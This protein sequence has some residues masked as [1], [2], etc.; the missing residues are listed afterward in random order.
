MEPAAQ[1]PVKPPVSPASTS[2]DT[3]QPTGEVKPLNIGDDAFSWLES[4]AAKQ[5]AKPEELLTKPNERSGEMPDW[6]RQPAD[7][8]AD[9]PV[10]PAQEPIR[11]PPETLPLKPLPWFDAQASKPAHPMNETVPAN[12]ETPSPVPP[13]EPTAQPANPAAGGEDDTMAW[14]EQMASDKDTKPEE[15]LPSPAKDVGTTPEWIQKV[16]EDQP[17]GSEPEEIIPATLESTP[18]Q[19]DISITSW[20]SKMDVDEALEKKLGENPAE[21]VPATPAEELPDWLKDLEKPVAPAE[22]PKADTDLPEWLRHPIPS[23][24]LESVTPAA[25]SDSIPEAEL[26]TWVDENAPVTGQAVPTMPEEWLPVET[27]AGEISSSLPATVP[28]PVAESTPNIDFTGVSDSAPVPPDEAKPVAETEPPAGSHPV[29]APTPVRPPTLKQTGMLSHI[30][31][32][33]KDA[34]LL[35]SAQNVLDQNSL[36]DAMKKYSKLIKKGRLLDEVIHDLR[37]AIYRYPVDVIVWQTLG[38]AYMRA[39]R[40]QDALDAYTKAEE[41]L[42]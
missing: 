37:E 38:D 8:A 2:A 1:V 41:L 4:L 26:P 31:V 19:E 29:S 12:D 35:S 27:N 36:D 39:N 11:T 25:E 10:P 34:E 22:A 30:P 17:A 15:P 6:L 40:L 20:L 18:T 42:R 33:D 7:K 13:V 21:A 9:A 24:S 28:A 14:L 5:G 32:L 3:F 16:Q 23:E